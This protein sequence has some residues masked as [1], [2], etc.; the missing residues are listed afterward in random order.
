MESSA[1]PLMT[2]ASLSVLV[3][4]MVIHGMVCVDKVMNRKLM[5]I[6]LFLSMKSF[7]LFKEMH[8]SLAIIAS[9]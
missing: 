5:G 2:V 9:V 8:S 6:C 3:E 7:S 1:I 4:C